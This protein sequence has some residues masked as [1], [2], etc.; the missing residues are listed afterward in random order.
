MWDGRVNENAGIQKSSERDSSRRC[1][2]LK[3]D[4]LLVSVE[5]FRPSG[6]EGVLPAF[7]APGYSL[8]PLQGT[9]K[10]PF[11]LTPRHPVSDFTDSRFGL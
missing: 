7:C 4:E 1:A 6:P 8:V 9:K 10:L 3:L 2:L 5:Q 11:G